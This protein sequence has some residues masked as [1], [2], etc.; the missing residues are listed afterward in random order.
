MMMMI[1]LVRN[2]HLRYIENVARLVFSLLFLRI[3]FV[4]SGFRSTDDLKRGKE[5]TLPKL[6]TG[7]NHFLLLKSQQCWTC[8]R[9]VHNIYIY[10]SIYL[11][12]YMQMAIYVYF[13]CLAHSQV[14]TTG[15]LTLSLSLSRSLVSCYFCVPNKKFTKN[16]QQIRKN[17]KMQKK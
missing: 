6:G 2:N 3:S 10:I 1:M 5:R 8:C 13:P 7:A 9:I 11:Y 15:S 14:F 17:N 16:Q 4:G 12:I